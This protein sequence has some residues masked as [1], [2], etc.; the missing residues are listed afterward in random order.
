[1]WPL[2]LKRLSDR[3]AGREDGRESVASADIQPSALLF[4][5]PVK[6]AKG[7]FCGQV[8]PRAVYM[9]GGG[10][11]V[12]HPPPLFKR[13]WSFLATSALADWGSSRAGFG[14][15]GCAGALDGESPRRAST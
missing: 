7:A 4:F 15:V 1:M 14:E 5:G 2:R 3:A 8:P 12:P 11:K 9:E 10:V 6:E 13:F